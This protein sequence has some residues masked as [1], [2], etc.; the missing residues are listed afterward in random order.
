MGKRTLKLNCKAIVCSLLLLLPMINNAQQSKSAKL[1]TDGNQVYL[2][3]FVSKTNGG[4]VTIVND[5][6]IKLSNT[7]GD[8]FAM[9]NGVQKLFKSFIYEADVKLISGVSASLVI[10]VQDL[11][12][13]WSRWLG[14]NFD[15]GRSDA[16]IRLFDVGSGRGDLMVSKKPDYLNFDDT[17]HMCIEVFENG[18]FIYTIG[19]PDSLK[20]TNQGHI[21]NW[22]GG[23]IGLLTY[24]SEMLFSN[25][26]FVDRTNYSG[27]KID[28]E[29]G[30][31]KTN[32]NELYYSN[33]SWSV[34][35]NGLTSIVSGDSFVFSNI[36]AKDFTYVADVT[37]NERKDCAA[38]LLLRG[39]KDTSNKNMYIANINP[40]T[41]LTRLFKFENNAAFDLVSPK[42]VTLTDDNKYHLEVT[43]IGKH[44]VFKVNGEVVANTADYTS[45]SIYGQ[46]DAI[47]EGYAGFLSW[48]ANATYQNAILTPITNTN[49]PQFNKLSISSVDGTVEHNIQYDPN[50]YVYIAYVSNS[51][52]AINLDVEKSTAS[53]EVIIT[54]TDNQVLSK[55]LPVNEGINTY[56][57][58]AKNADATI[59]YRI[60]VIRRKDPESYYNEEYRDQYHFS[61]KEGWAND[62]NGLVY[63]NGEYHLFHQFY[64]ALN[65]GPMHWAHSVSKDLIHWEELPIAF[66]PDEYGAMYSGSAVVDETNTSGLFTEEDGSTSLTGGMVSIITA[67]GNGERVII[68]YSKDGRNWKKKEGVVK[69]WTEDP[70]NNSAFR[71]PKVFRYQ[72]KWFMVIAGGPLRIYSSDNLIDWTVESTYPGLETECPDLYRLPVME[73]NQIA[74]Y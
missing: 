8:H 68:A 39:N 44:I 24:Q 38:S 43:A 26:K 69:D 51:T 37:F 70:L 63:Y 64:T 17:L 23:Y 12:N 56:T 20:L 18:D 21:S 15:R 41:G 40:K 47:L 22:T 65:W 32:L 62:P 11:A 66:Y 50:Q 36:E 4:T 67:D 5:H 57:L 74:T 7:G 1:L 35:K 13:P 55:D 73:N 27:T 42:T 19:N 29:S 59:L 46:N 16:P 53:T 9:Y 3:D 33:G 25:I 61:V 49:N 2:T 58:T 10:G 28:N 45:S 71:D 54:N 34:G 60:V 48:E 72:N 52:T 30:D 6:A 31:L 14:V